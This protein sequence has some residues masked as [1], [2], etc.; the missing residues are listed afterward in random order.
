MGQLM[1]KAPPAATRVQ[2]CTTEGDTSDPQVGGDPGGFNAIAVDGDLVWFGSKS[3]LG[4]FDGFEFT[5][6]YTKDGLTDDRITC[7][8]ITRDEMWVGTAEGLNRLE[9]D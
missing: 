5:N 2:W 1:S 7:L 8:F 6:F 9:K 3:G 4:V